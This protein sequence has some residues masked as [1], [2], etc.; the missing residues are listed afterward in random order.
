MKKLKTKLL[1]AGAAMIFLST[2]AQNVY[3]GAS[4]TTTAN[5]TVSSTVI[6]SCT[7]SVTALSFGSY[8]G[9]VLTGTATISPTCTNGTTYNV[10]ISAGTASGATVNARKMTNGASTLNYSLLQS[11]GGSNWGNT[12]GSD[13]V[14]KTGDGTTQT[15]TVFG[16][17]PAS[18]T[19]PLGSY[20]D[21]VVV[22]ITF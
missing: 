1:I 20:S 8:T 5:M 3:A 15:L 17:I 18:Q 16:T 2:Q 11:S 21:T 7:V 9:S 13:T 12:V 6:A 19:S 22:T 14:P 4:N 10:G